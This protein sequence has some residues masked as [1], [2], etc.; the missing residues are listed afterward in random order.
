MSVGR[1]YWPQ[2]R[3]STG[4]GSARIASPCLGP[5]RGLVH[6]V[7]LAAEAP[8]PRSGE[9]EGRRQREQAPH[10][11]VGAPLVPAT[12]VGAAERRRRGHPHEEEGQDAVSF[13]E[14]LAEC[15]P[16]D[17]LVQAVHPG[18]PAGGCDQEADPRHHE[19][20]A[21]PGHREAAVA[22]RGEDQEHERG[23]RDDE[24]LAAHVEVGDPE[25]LAAGEAEQAEDTVDPGVEGI[26]SRRRHPLEADDDTRHQPGE[27]ADDERTEDPPGPPSAVGD[28]AHED[29]GPLPGSRR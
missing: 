6:R 5:F 23:E 7:E 12:E 13:S 18:Q 22:G 15:R 8:E 16:R 20:P 3:A 25:P 19:R 17:V 2:G 9:G 14:G 27:L 4:P 29:R 21:P 11:V 1:T 26:G 24:P 28:Q 10:E